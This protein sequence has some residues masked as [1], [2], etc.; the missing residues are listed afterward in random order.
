M[1][2]T[3]SPLALYAPR[4]RS[5]PHRKRRLGCSLAVLVNLYAPRLLPLGVIFQDRDVAGIDGFTDRGLATIHGSSLCA[6]AWI[7]FD[8]Q[9]DDWLSIELKFS[10]DYAVLS[11]SF[12]VAM[13]N[14]ENGG[15]CLGVHA[16]H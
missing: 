14:S 12:I 2:A 1:G 9:A 3:E 13:L 11:E 10:A 16:V 7:P 4:C 5:R 8:F 15:Q 6:D